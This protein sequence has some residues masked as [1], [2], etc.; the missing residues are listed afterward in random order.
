M[1]GDDAED[2]ALEFVERMLLRQDW[3]VLGPIKANTG[4]GALPEEPVVEAWLLRCAAN[5]AHN[6]R[7]RGWRIAAR[8]LPWPEREN[9]DGARSP[10]EGPAD[11]NT[12]ELLLLRTELERQVQAS[13]GRL[14]SMQQD[15]FERHVLREESL[16]E[17]AQALGRS[18]HALSQ[19]L[20]TLRRR[21]RGLLERQ[22]VDEAETQQSR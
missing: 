13:V 8:E 22:G 7:R 9:S 2:C 21:L 16:Q 18:P 15:L 19:A 17:I 20:L 3:R 12:P 10:W 14:T 5:F 1:D 4:R 11:P 6:F